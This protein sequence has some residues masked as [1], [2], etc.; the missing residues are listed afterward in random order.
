MSE[1]W[2]KQRGLMPGVVPHGV[3]RRAAVAG[4]DTY[5]GP[6]R[7]A[8]FHGYPGVSSCP[9][10]RSRN[11]PAQ[12]TEGLTWKLAALPSLSSRKRGLCCSVRKVGDRDFDATF[13]RSS[14]ME[15]PT[16]AARGR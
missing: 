8:F 4:L 6:F 1:R 13:Q 5:Q 3:L 12:Q 7:A 15:S 2:R 9:R 16:E 10:L 11:P 14:T